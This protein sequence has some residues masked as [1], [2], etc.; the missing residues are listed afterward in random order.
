MPQLSFPGVYVQEVSS[1]VR[2]ITGVATAVTAFVG[3]TRQGPCDEAVR[4]HSFGEFERI[5]GGLWEES[6]LSYAVRDYYR[7]GGQEAVI[8]RRYTAPVTSGEGINA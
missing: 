7:N 6:G 4:I 2:A 3:R 8:V 1:G 5:F